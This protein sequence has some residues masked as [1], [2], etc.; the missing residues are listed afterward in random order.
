MKN[1]G[2]DESMEEVWNE[3]RGDYGQTTIKNTD[4][5]TINLNLWYEFY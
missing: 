5:I 2:V 3:S 1:N 4:A